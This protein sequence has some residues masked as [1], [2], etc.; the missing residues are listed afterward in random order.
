MEWFVVGSVKVTK[1]TL[2]VKRF[3]DCLSKIYFVLAE[4]TNQL[5]AFVKRRTALWDSFP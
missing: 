2:K 4:A 5:T 1:L 3:P